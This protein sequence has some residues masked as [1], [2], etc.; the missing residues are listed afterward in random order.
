MVLGSVSH[1]IPFIL[2]G[3]SFIFA[4]QQVTKRFLSKILV[5]TSETISTEKKFNQWL[6]GV[7]DGDGYLGIS[8]AGYTSLE[9]TT[10]PEDLPMLQ[11]IM[12]RFGGTIKARSGSKSIRYRLMKKSQMIDL[13]NCING[14]IHNSIRFAQFEKVCAILQISLLSPCTLDYSNSWF[15]GMFDADGTVTLKTTG[16]ITIGV[17][18]KLNEN[19]IAFER[20]LGG[21]IYLDKSQNGYYKWQVQSKGDVLGILDYFKENPCYS[22]K[23]NR[24]LLIPR[25]ISLLNDKYHLAPANSAQYKEWLLL[26][27]D[28]TS[29]R[30]GP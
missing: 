16:Q 10:T 22:L 15:S 27:S 20:I 1:S 8:K 14:N 30:Y 18:Q 24:L 5:G 21:N 26:V 4:N 12:D 29:S 3:W 6:G 7:I 13:V 2:I 17:T 28:W 9:I 19:I 25:V 23:S 11:R